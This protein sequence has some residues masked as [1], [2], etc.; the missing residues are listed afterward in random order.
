[1]WTKKGELGQLKEE[2]K[3]YKERC[4]RLQ[5]E[6]DQIRHY[7]NLEIE[8]LKAS[9]QIALKEKAFELTHYKDEQMQAMQLKV[10][11]LNEQV[12]VLKKENQML[13]KI[14]DLN[15]DLIDIKDLVS[16]LI[17]KLPE[18]NLSSLTVKN[19]KL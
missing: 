5:Q 2:I 1:M 13:E 16:K 8:S 17:G 10:H 11:Q 7:N 4:L 15:G 18:I 3:S 19:G 14:T 9:H 12:A 6:A